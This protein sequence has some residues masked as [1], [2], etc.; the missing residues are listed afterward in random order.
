M[1]RSGP[2]GQQSTGWGIWDRINHLVIVCKAMV[3]LVCTLCGP[4]KS[5]LNEYIPLRFPG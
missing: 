3:G 4:L 5:G 1:N 2:P